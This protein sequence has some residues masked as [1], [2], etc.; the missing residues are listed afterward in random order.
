M[1]FI[2][3]SPEN[4]LFLFLLQWYCQASAYL[5]TDLAQSIDML[6]KGWRE[7]PPL[8]RRMMMMASNETPLKLGFF[9]MSVAVVLKSFVCLLTPDLQEQKAVSG[10]AV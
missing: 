6:V 2:I 1:Q 10:F 5:K 7:V 9:S 3:T 8:K 4:S